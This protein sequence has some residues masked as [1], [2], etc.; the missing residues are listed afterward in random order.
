M[1]I[2]HTTA[3]CIFF[4]VYIVSYIIIKVSECSLSNSKILWNDPKWD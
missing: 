4:V 2:Y 1:D 3:A